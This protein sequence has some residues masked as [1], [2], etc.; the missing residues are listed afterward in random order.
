[1]AQASG[2]LNVVRQIGGSFGV[3][4]FGTMLA[5]RTIYHTARYGEQVD[6]Y[7]KTFRETLMH[8]QMW[9]VHTAG[10]SVA[11]AA[12]KAKAL[13]GQFLGTQA[14]IRATDDVFLLAGV[15]L[16]AGIIP[17]LFVRRRRA[18]VHPAGARPVAAQDS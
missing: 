16:L 18:G 7:S 9:V 6:Q 11:S 2:L 17:L 1:M 10:G 5:R 3:A 13:I 12:G 4:V 15:I 8:V 14:F